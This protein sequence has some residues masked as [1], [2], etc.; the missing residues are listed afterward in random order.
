MNSRL[1]PVQISLKELPAEGR[2]FTYSQETGELNKIL[3][4]LIGRNKY[5]VKIKM[6]PVGNSFDL[7]GSIS[8]SMDLQCALCAIAFSHLI[9]VKLHELI[10]VQKPMAKGDQQ[11]RANHAHEWESSGP[12]YI[13]LESETFEI[14]Q[15]IHEMVALAEPLKPLGR[16]DCDKNCENL[17][18]QVMRDWLTLGDEPPNSSIKANPF[19]V[20]EKIKLKG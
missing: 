5:S 9:Q 16:P 13:V 18:D 20:L 11:T 12:D 3:L 7:R 4:P 15:Y 6:T 17:T 2:E 14:D 10:V 19:K 1:N 8:T